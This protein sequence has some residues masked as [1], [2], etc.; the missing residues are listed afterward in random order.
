MRRARRA[1][2]AMQFLWINLVSDIFPGLALA[3]EPPEPMS[4]SGPQGPCG[5]D[6]ATCPAQKDVEGGSRPF[7]RLARG[8]RVRPV[9]L[10]TGAGRGHHGVPQP[11][12]KP[13]PARAHVP[14]GKQDGFLRR[15]AGAEPLPDRGRRWHVPASGG[16]DSRAGP[17]R[18]LGI[19][20][21]GLVDGL[22]AGGGAVLP[23]FVNE[24]LKKSRGGAA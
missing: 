24:A 14:L 19:S 17:R 13:A 6:T 9:P 15:K 5:G 10:R 3:L 1:A 2:S 8:I 16:R 11:H 4:S 18:L 22:V 20:R 23:F 12:Y 21:L 7:R